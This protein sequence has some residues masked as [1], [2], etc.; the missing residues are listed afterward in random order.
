MFHTIATRTLGAVQRLVGLAQPVLRISGSGD[1]TDTGANGQLPFWQQLGFLHS[2]A[3]LVSETNAVP[4]R[5]FTEQHSELLA[6]VT[7]QCIY[8]PNPA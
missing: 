3:Q 5:R 8:A 4:R 7:A 1:V 6:T 2:L